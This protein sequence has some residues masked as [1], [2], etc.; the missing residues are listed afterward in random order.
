MPCDDA[1]AVLG[2]DDGVALLELHAAPG[3]RCA[4]HGAVS[5]PVGRLLKGRGSRRRS[6]QRCG[7]SERSSDGR[8]RRRRSPRPSGRPRC[9]PAPARRS[10]G[11]LVVAA[12]RAPNGHRVWKPAAGRRAGRRR[13][14]AL[15][16]DAARGWPRWPGRAPAP[17]TA[18]PSCTGAAARSNTSSRSAQLDDPPEV[19]HRHP[20]A[21]VLDH[22]QVVGDEHQREVEPALQVAQQVQDLRLDRHVE[23]RHRLVGHEEARVDDE[24]AGDA[25]PLA[26]AAAELMRVAPGVVRLEAD[27]GEHLVDPLGPRLA[28]ARPGPAGPRRCCRR[29]WPG[30]RARRRDPGTRSASG[31]AGAAARS[32][33]AASRS[34]AV[35]VDRCR[36]RARAAAG[37]GARACSC[38]SPTRPPGRAPRRC[39]T[40][41][42]TPSTACT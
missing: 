5:S 12:G 18:A 24:G 17:P 14:V 38:R 23:G 27:Q 32:P 29:R 25:D 1:G 28:A 15:Q 39:S 40:S 26:L 4:A 30:G 37:A 11:D 42:S 2:V 3:G 20:V 16:H 22:A 41:R 10:C 36:R 8:R 9:G 31:R 13:Q 34:D 33:L 35:E 6:H 19:H 7:P 21:Q